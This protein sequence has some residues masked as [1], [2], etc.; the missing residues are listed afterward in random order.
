M[1]AAQ[2]APL[3]VAPVSQEAVAAAGQRRLLVTVLVTATD[4]AGLPRGAEAF[5]KGVHRSVP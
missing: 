1:G 4:L 5:S 3:N 2:L